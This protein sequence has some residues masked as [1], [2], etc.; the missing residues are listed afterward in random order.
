M[1][2]LR[3]LTVFLAAALPL[4]LGTPDML[5]DTGVHAYRL[6]NGMQIIVAVRPELKLAAMNLT[7]GLGSIDDPAGQSGVAHLLE[8]VTLS[9][10]TTIGSL[11]PVAEAEALRDLDR[12]YAALEGARRSAATLPEALVG[13]GQWFEQTQ[14]AAQ[15]TCEAG[16]ILGGRL[17]E[18][19]AVGLNATTT[20]DT[21]HFFAWIPPSQLELWISLEADRLRNPVFRRFYTER[22]VVLREVTTLT[23]GTATIL[24]RFVQE[25]FGAAEPHLLAGDP[26]EIST[27]D[28]PT[29]LAYFRR[30]YV[31]RNIAVAVV[32]NVDPEQVHRLSAR[33]FGDWRPDD[34]RGDTESSFVATRQVIEPRVGKFNSVRNPVVLMAFPRAAVTNEAALEALAE[35]INSED[36]SPLQRRLRQE[37]ALAWHIRAKAKYPSEKAASIFLL[38]LYGNAGV[39]HDHL[40]EEAWRVLEAFDAVPDNDIEGA[41][42]AAEL[43]AAT[44]MDDPPTLASLLASSQV[45]HGDWKMPFRR[46]DA[47]NGLTATEVRKAARSLFSRSAVSEPAGRRP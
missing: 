2:R 11:D 37:R 42:R 19:G 38:Q 6:G 3:L 7:V 27:I 23:R 36:L 44:R 9:G 18:R 14:Q 25:L 13:L 12:A 34:R 41:I 29:A 26:A 46:V 16:E 30:R 5:T 15:R 28:R 17:E 33:Y 47:L 24:E 10:S 35:L 32:G 40:A 20:E 21:T 43:H 22:N 39:R 4:R 8:H 1:M 45:I 31:P